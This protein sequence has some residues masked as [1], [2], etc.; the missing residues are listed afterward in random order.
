MY[1]ACRCRSFLIGYEKPGG[2]NVSP[3]VSH[4]TGPLEQ[5]EPVELFYPLKKLQEIKTGSSGS[6]TV[7]SEL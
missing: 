5:D 7:T 1:S 4:V 3:G 2:S 6:V